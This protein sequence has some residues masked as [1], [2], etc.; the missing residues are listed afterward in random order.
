[1]ERLGRKL[2]EVCR[3]HVG[4]VTLCDKAYIFPAETMGDGLMCA[5][6]KLRGPIVMEEGILRPVIKGSTLKT[7]D[8]PV[9]HYVLFPYQKLEGKHR[10]LP[11]AQLQAQYPLAYAYLQSVR[12]E[13]DKRDNGTLNPVA[14]YAFGRSQ[15]LETSWGKKIIFSPMNAKP[16]FILHEREDCTVYS[17]YFIKYDGDYHALLP[18]LNSTE[19]EQ[20]VAVSS[21][22]FRGAWKAYSKKVIEDFVVDL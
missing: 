12:D 22:D 2:K 19:M 17:G 9:T 13:L 3:I 20:F 18:R 6:T 1:M 8:D 15:G 4:I 11:E 5:K 7:S 16:N 14:W 10:I 21:R